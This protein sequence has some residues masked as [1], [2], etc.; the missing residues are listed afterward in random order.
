MQNDPDPF[1]NRRARAISPRKV[2]ERRPEDARRAGHRP[3]RRPAAKERDRRQPRA[4]QRE[5]PV[6]SRPRRP[7]HASTKGELQIR[8]RLQTHNVQIGFFEKPAWTAK[9]RP[10][11]QAAIEDPWKAP[12][13]RGST[14]F[15]PANGA[16]QPA[17]NLDRI[18]SGEP[19]WFLGQA[20][21]YVESGLG[22]SDSGHSAPIRTAVV[23]TTCPTSRQ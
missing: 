2:E 22:L 16:T 12:P 11:N 3:R 21:G 7:S 20:A 17:R 9:P 4:D 18:R 15:R 6:S 1:R 10:S 19:T 13:E 14:L 5:P 23:E 8:R